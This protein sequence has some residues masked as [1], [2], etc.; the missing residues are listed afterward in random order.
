MNSAWNHAVSDQSATQHRTSAPFVRSS[1]RMP[2]SGRTSGGPGP[3]AATT[4]STADRMAAGGLPELGAGALTA[5]LVPRL[6]PTRPTDAS[7]GPV[8]RG[9]WWLL[10]Q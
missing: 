8:S 6:R 3:V 9:K 2:E 5:A 4:S 1:A 7:E 10:G